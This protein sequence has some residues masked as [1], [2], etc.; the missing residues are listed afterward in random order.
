MTAGTP[1]INWSNFLTVLITGLMVA[2]F[3]QLKTLND[4]TIEI[5]IIAN[6]QQ[7]AIQQLILADKEQRDDIKDLQRGMK[8]ELRSR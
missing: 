1:Q 5:K 4:T 7:Q 6:T 2:C 8:N 3:A